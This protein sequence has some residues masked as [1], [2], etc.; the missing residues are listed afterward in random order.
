MRIPGSGIRNT[1]SNYNPKLIFN[2]LNQNL[3]IIFFQFFD[4]NGIRNFIKSTCQKKEKLFTITFLANS[5]TRTTKEMKELKS[6][7]LVSVF[8]IMYKLLREEEVFNNKETELI[9]CTL[10]HWASLGKLNE[11]EYSENETLLLNFGVNININFI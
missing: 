8:L 2:D 10:C 11:D 4:D 7:H 3:T 6:T 9:S 1:K 5:L